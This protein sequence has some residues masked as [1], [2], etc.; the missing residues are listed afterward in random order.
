V[1]ETSQQL[2]A[3]A[4]NPP[5]MAAGTA[6]RALAGFLLSGVLSS[7]LGAMLPLWRHYLT[8]DY[9][10]VGNYFLSMNLGLV[11]ALWVAGRLFER[12]S[13]RVSLVVACSL[14]CAALLYLAAIPPTFSPWWRMGGVLVI[15]CGAGLLNTSLFH[16]I[17]PLYHRDSTSTLNLGGTLFGLGCVAIAI[18]IAGTFYVYTVA[19]ILIFIALIP[20]F[21]IAL[22]ARSSFPA[23]ISGPQL[24]WKQAL[25]D[26]RS[27]TAVLF[28]L[29]LFFQF[30]NEW[31]IAGWLPLFLIQRLGISPESSLVMLAVYWLALLV[32]RVFVLSVL[33]AV[34]HGK[35]LMVSVLGALLGC[36]VLISTNNPFGAVMG[37]LLVG[38][39]FASVYPL[40]A[41]KI[42][43]RFPYYHPG[44]FGGI[45]SFALTGGLLATWSLGLFTRLWGIRVVML[46]PLLG[47]LMVF[48][49]L[50]VLWA[51]AAFSNAT[52]EQK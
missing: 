15:G 46:L 38:G 21:F 30:G 4:P 28:A 51:E 27:P 33:P 13:I 12:A 14:A 26:F 5:V 49:L 20:G 23:E 43:A 16:A 19:S 17:A 24:P 18:L 29:V 41:E 8:E 50:L 44:L 52:K 1:A 11:A 45:F 34:H 7:F 22:Y 31:S 9:L 48:V 6:R 35:L 36:V 37:I 2:R 10:T 40:V 39:A 32:G 47:T 42:G 25:Q 3:T